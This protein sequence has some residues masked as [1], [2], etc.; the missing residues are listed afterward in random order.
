MTININEKPSGSR[1][2][3]WFCILLD[4]VVPICSHLL[5]CLNG[6]IKDPVKDAGLKTNT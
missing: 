5:V 4:E 3:I 1:A 2:S 6:L